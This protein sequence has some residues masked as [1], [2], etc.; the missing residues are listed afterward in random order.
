MGAKTKR[1]LASYKTIKS[2]TDAKRIW[3]P[4]IKCNLSEKLDFSKPCLF[5]DLMTT[6][7]QGY[8]TYN[9]CTR[10]HL[11]LEL[12]ARKIRDSIINSSNLTAHFKNKAPM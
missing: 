3:N 12:N 6:G 8:N 4:Q 5:V 10:P 2:S 11:P 7:G 1:L 9:K